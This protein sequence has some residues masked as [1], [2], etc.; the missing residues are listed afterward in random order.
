MSLAGGAG[1]L[2]EGRQ[3]GTGDGCLLCSAGCDP[4]VLFPYL[5]LF[6]FLVTSL[7]GAWHPYKH[8]T[9]NFQFARLQGWRMVALF[10]LLLLSFG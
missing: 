1:A 4:R 5:I 10:L 2:C 8:Y 9:K 6:L 3:G 7:C